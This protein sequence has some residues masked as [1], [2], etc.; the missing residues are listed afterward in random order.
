[1]YCK[2]VSLTQIFFILL[3]M[4]GHCRTFKPTYIALAQETE[5]EHPNVEFYAVSCVAH[6]DMC[7]QFKVNSY[8]TLYTFA[9]GGDSLPKVLSQKNA[10]LAGVVEALNLDGGNS[11]AQPNRKLED[12]DDSENNDVNGEDADPDEDPDA[13]EETEEGDESSRDGFDVPNVEVTIADVPDA[14]ENISE[15]LDPDMEEDIVEDPFDSQDAIEDSEMNGG[16]SYGSQDEEEEDGENSEVLDD[17]EEPETGDEDEETPSDSSDEPD[18]PVPHNVRTFNGFKA[19]ANAARASPLEMDKYKTLLQKQNQKLKKKR[20]GLSLRPKAKVDSHVELG[21][22]TSR[23]KA[24]TP[25][26]REF[27]MREQHI[28]DAIKKIERRDRRN[29]QDI[30]SSKIKTGRTRIPVKKAV[31][32]PRF[33]EKVPFIKRVVRMSNEESLIL[34]TNLSF[35]HGLQFGV[36]TSKDALPAKK[37]RALKNWLDL[38][39]VS[40]PAEWALHDLIDDLLKNIDSISESDENLSKILTKYKTPRSVWSDS[41]SKGVSGGQFSCGVWKLFHTVTVGVAE[42]RGGLNLLKSEVVRPNTHMFSPLEAAD[43][44]RDYMENF[45]LCSVCQTNFIAIYDKCKNNRRCE[46]LTDDAG[47]ASSADWKELSSWFWEVHN[48]V[49]VRLL[50]ERADKTRTQMQKSGVGRGVAGPGA[51]SMLDEVKVLWPTISECLTCFFDDGSWNQ[52]G[53]FMFMEK[54][55]W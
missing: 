22:A 43:T 2:A 38:L 52:D 42:H 18:A 23:M 10:S 11:V 28:S 49:N 16:G 5:V 13:D 29:D 45:F 44:I 46:R 33:A 50:N 19:G 8:P 17:E 54:T 51:A 34:D 3:Q 1:M 27:I 48:D 41:C 40:L 37:R 7:Q 20:G 55:Y 12:G 47:G 35:I 25:G 14:E 4:Q 31:K 9:E 24:Y 32:K 6:K 36:F 15:D 26:T 30:S 39:S 21:A 53:I